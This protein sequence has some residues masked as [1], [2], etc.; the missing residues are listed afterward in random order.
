[1]GFRSIKSA[2]QH[3]IETSGDQTQAAK[4]KENMCREGWETDTNLP[5]G[6]LKK[7]QN[8]GKKGIDVKIFTTEGK[9]LGSYKTVK[10]FM[11]STLLFNERY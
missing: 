1:M 5:I 7:I 9:V 3:L 10:H 11:L 4:M 2:L 8:R 6:W